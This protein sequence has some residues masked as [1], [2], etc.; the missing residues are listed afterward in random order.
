MKRLNLLSLCPSVLKFTKFEAQILK[1][2]DDFKRD[3]NRKGSMSHQSSVINGEK[4][5]KYSRVLENKRQMT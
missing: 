3:D 1:D 5:R 4:Q 2:D